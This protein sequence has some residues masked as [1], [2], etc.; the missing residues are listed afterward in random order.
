M[1][2]YNAPIKRISIALK[3]TF[4][5][6]KKGSALIYFSGFNNCISDHFSFLLTNYSCYMFYLLLKHCDSVIFPCER[7][8]FFFSS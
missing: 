5:W 4:S 6:G 3:K 1:L 7:E 8:I 2:M